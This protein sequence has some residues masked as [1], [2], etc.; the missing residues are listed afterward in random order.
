MKLPLFW[1]A[2][3]AGLMPV[4]AVAAG[5]IGLPRGDHFELALPTQQ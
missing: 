4:S 5:F 3:D 2:V 1:V